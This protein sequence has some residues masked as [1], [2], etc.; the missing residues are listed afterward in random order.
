M[1]CLTINFGPS[2]MFWTFLYRDEKAG[3]AMHDRLINALGFGADNFLHG[4]SDDF[5]QS[6]SFR[7]SEIHGV[8]FEDL[9][10]SKLAHVE[11]GLHNARTQNDYVKRVQSDP[12]ARPMSQGPGVLAPMGGNGLF[13]PQ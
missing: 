5:G 1:H 13:R 2:G 8:L 3:Q 12:S 11:K 7:S 9:D 6:G 4:I 10:Q